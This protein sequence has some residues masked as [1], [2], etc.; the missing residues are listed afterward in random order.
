MAGYR[1]LG[2]MAL[3]LPVALAWAPVPAPAADRAT[4]TLTIAKGEREWVD[5]FIKGDPT[6]IDRLLADDFSGLDVHGRRY[7]KAEMRK[8][9]A[10]G[11]SL[12]SDD[13]GPLDIRFYGDVA[14]AYG[15]E[16]QVGPAPD[17]KPADRVWTDVWVRRDGRWQ[18][19][20]ATDV[21]PALR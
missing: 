13:L 4:D 18:I 3:A 7:T 6:I 10:E 12:T 9:A 14:I 21:D 15:S 19:V 17:H 8:W 11:P 20:A 5:A 2:L 1:H 16:H